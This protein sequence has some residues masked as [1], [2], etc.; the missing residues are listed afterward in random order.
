[1]RD[2]LHIGE[3]GHHLACQLVARAVV[4]TNIS[5]SV[6]LNT[7][8]ALERRELEGLRWDTVLPV[9]DIGLL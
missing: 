5:S 2:L 4:V 1:M 8:D 7:F 6:I 3:A 9:F